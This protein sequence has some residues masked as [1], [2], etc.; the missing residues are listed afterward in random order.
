MPTQKAPSRITVMEIRKDLGLGQRRV[1][2]MLKNNIIP[3]VRLGRSW[4]VARHAYEQWKQTAGMG[5]ST[6]DLP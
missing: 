2:F 6:P 3:N 5:K 1:Y 4:I